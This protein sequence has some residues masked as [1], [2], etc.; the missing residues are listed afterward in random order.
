LMARSFAGITR[1]ES[2]EKPSEYAFTQRDLLHEVLYDPGPWSLQK[3]WHIGA[4]V[5][6]TRTR[7]VMR[8]EYF[9]STVEELGGGTAI[10]RLRGE[11]DLA[12]RPL[13]D[14]AM[15][16]VANRGYEAI[17]MDGTGIDFMDSTGW[18]AFREGKRLIYGEGTKLI[19]VASKSMQH[20]LELLAPTPLFAAR[21]DSIEEAL[22]LLDG[23]VEL[24]SQ[25]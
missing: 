6:T 9:T 2:G 15:R 12:T 24:S 5:P 25:D 21:V 7:I 19:L 13:L 22:A 1:S 16:D 11:I 8:D 3:L 14:E 10:L 23:R 4:E 18:H 17:I 20:V